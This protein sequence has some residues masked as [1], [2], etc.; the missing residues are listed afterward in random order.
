M[1]QKP[2]KILQASAGSGKTFSLTAHYLTLL[3]AGDNRYR[4]IL[5][6]TFTNKATEEMKS[7]IL[8]VLRGLALGDEKFLTFQE[9]I[10]RAHPNLNA[11]SLKLKADEI[12]RRILHDYSH[13]AIN[14]IDGFVQK[15]IR[16]LSF[17]LGLDAGYKLEMN[18]GKVK[19]E[20]A[21]KL[22]KKL[23][24]NPELL[25]WI[26]D[27]ALDRIRDNKSWNYRDTLLSL[28]GEIFK[29]RYQPFENALKQY[30]PK[31]L[32][33]DL[34]DFTRQTLSVVEETLLER[35]KTA[36]DIFRQSG[37]D[38][39]ELKGKSKSPLVNLE[40]IGKGDFSKIKSVAKLIDA[41]DEWQKGVLTV[42]VSSLYDEL[43]PLL[44]S[45]SEFYT[46]QLPAYE[47]AKAINANL[48]YLRLMQE[49][50]AL[51]K[52]YR[53][54][55]S[56][57]LISDAQ[58]LLKGITG[59]HQDNPSF[60]WEKLGSRYRHFLFDEFQDTSAMQWENFLPLVKNAIAE[61]NGSLIDHLI[62]GDV[63]QSIYRWRNG[64]W[65]ILLQRARADV[66]ALQVLDDSL[67]ENYR[68]AANII[69]FNNFLFRHSPAMLQN[70]LNEKVRSDGGEGLFSDWWQKSGFED[71]IVK[72]YGQSLQQKSPVTASG[73][74]VEINYL[75]VENN[76]YRDSQCREKTLEHL[77]STINEW[78]STD[79]YQAGQICVLVRSNKEA[80]S[81]I[82][83]LM[84]DQQNRQNE[85]RKDW[86]PYQVLSGE[87]LLLANNSA[88]KL[89]INTFKAMVAQRGQSALYKLNM[90]Q[91][92][93]RYQ[94]RTLKPDILLQINKTPVEKLKGHL[95]EILCDNWLAWQQMPLSELVESL[96]GAYGLNTSELHLPYILAFRDMVSN[97]SKQ[98]EKGI[99]SFLDWWHEESEQKALPSSG[100]G[101][102]VQVMTIHK[103]KGLAFDVVMIP[104]C[105]W[106]IDG[107]ANSIFWVDTINTP[108]SM[109]NT[110]PVNYKKTLAQSAF[111]QAYFKE[112]LFNYMDA[113]NMLYV[114]VTRT[115][116]HLYISSPGHAPAKEEQ[117][118]LAGDLIRVPL[119]TYVSE[120]NAEFDGQTL[121]IEE[122]VV[123]I[124]R[125]S[126]ADM[127]ESDRFT[128]STWNFKSYPLSDR[129]NEAL[130]DKKVFEQL[131]LLSGN[132]SQRRGIIL[133]E[134]LARVNNVNEI[135]DALRQLHTE[136]FFRKAEEADLQ[137]LAESVL[138][139]PDL[140]SLL[141]RPYASLNEQTIISGTG[142]SYRPDKV[143]IGK[144]HV[145]VIDFKFTGQPN[146]THYK[147]V[148]DYRK[149][150]M[151]MGYQNIEAYLYYGYLKELRAVDSAVYSS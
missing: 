21:N 117:F 94:H 46:E 8:E 149:L 135:P 82:E 145:V 38:P 41:P 5:A 40:K 96:I 124:S 98:G 20:L 147:Q 131:D 71:I 22:N 134:L 123:K 87:A 132:T 67:E 95:P 49:M 1:S 143:L 53:Q 44:R 129:L 55:N 142:E 54:E 9:I 79:R 61:A 104:F 75:P 28:A 85:G 83:H 118:S 121:L 81:V 141:D 114:A 112:L 12:Y 3:F 59:S 86:K 13:F 51:L 45:M 125:S 137:S 23:D 58:N 99:N 35:S 107:M 52:D 128:T 106:E 29:E 63:K 34:Q 150:L 119:Q 80:R 30:D 140:R 24:S 4:E 91:L 26:I 7:R 127:P 84:Q 76:K 14:T 57:L 74:T 148:D 151:E 15:V 89:L 17:E 39:A 62:V 122:P 97:F 144:D 138:T 25:E 93:A 78:I 139:N 116:K 47:M 133:H 6:V 60:V 70:H 110:I 18:T 88:V 146:S 101:N 31:Q 90:L 42:S 48:Y 66:G 120:L 109:L 56:T 108:Y 115:R 77:A 27:L 105:S 126:Q 69:D 73:G 64:D 102:A 32:F 2:L 33:K 136:G 10:L 19:E 37:V 65:Q 113:L 36:L 111:N 130:K 103:S 11:E 100:Q 92:F 68:S 50:A 43:N 16:S 72:A